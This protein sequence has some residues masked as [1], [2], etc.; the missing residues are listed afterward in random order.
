MAKIEL[1][2]KEYIP[3]DERCSICGKKRGKFLCDFPLARVQNMHLRDE[4]TG[5]TDYKNSFKIWTRTCDR[6]ICE[7][8]VIDMGDGIHICKK[9][10]AR[11][12]EIVK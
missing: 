11:F 7:D 3:S 4:K 10:S 9:C 2:K 6:L 1:F 5:E 12:L 8:C